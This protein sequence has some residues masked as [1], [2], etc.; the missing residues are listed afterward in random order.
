M[1]AVPAHKRCA[2]PK[3]NNNILRGVRR[4]FSRF[5]KRFARASRPR[6]IRSS[7]YV[8]VHL[9]ITSARARCKLC[10]QIDFTAE[11]IVR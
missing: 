4:P 1:Y 11:T 8:C 10:E 7:N 5:A 3:C 6:E 9:R 2:R